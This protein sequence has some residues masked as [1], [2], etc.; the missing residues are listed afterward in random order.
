MELTDL[1]M[2][3]FKEMDGVR[4][5]ELTGVADDN[6]LDLAGI[7]PTPEKICGSAMCWYLGSPTRKMI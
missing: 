7:F 5:K 4:H 1:V 2:L 6:I 3:D